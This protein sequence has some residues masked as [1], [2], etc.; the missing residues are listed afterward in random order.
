MSPTGYFAFELQL[1]LPQTSVKFTLRAPSWPAFVTTTAFFTVPY[2]VG[3][4]GGREGE[5]SYHSHGREGVRGRGGA[6]KVGAQG[7]LLRGGVGTRPWLCGFLRFQYDFNRQAQHPPPRQH[8]VA[9]IPSPCN[10]PPVTA[11]YAHS[12]RIA[13][14]SSGSDDHRRWH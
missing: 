6:G 14:M 4:G 5:A 10:M 12:H 11:P 9:T 13:L 3:G 8:A 7:M 2:Q 1:P